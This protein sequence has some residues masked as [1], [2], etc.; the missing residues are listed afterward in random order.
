[1]VEDGEE[2]DVAASSSMMCS[3][4]A[5]KSVTKV[6][7]PQARTKTA[8]RRR[9]SCVLRSASSLAEVA[10]TPKTIPAV[11][12]GVIR[13]S[14]SVIRSLSAIVHSFNSG[15]QSLCTRVTDELKNLES[16][17]ASPMSFFHVFWLPGSLV[18]SWSR[19]SVFLEMV[20]GK[21]FERIDGPITLVE[22]APAA[23]KTRSCSTRILGRLG[24]MLDNVPT[25]SSALSVG[26]M[27]RFSPAFDFSDWEVDAPSVNDT[28]LVVKMAVSS[29]RKRS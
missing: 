16:L 11:V 9:L 14:I 17:K 6:S 12:G 4:I 29:R 7:M 1:M 20:S 10:P 2:V 23:V 25:T 5:G 26:D 18:S 3:R 28:G 27:R 22:I 24:T 21:A 8:I 13:L 15:S 19:V